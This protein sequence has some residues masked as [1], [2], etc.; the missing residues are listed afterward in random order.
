[1][2]YLYPTTTVY[3]LS[4]VL[5]NAVMKTIKELPENLTPQEVADYLRLSIETINRRIRDKQIDFFR[6]NERG[7]KRIPK[8]AVIEF[9]EKFNK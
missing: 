6:I 4:N 9:I 7:D 1:M 5:Y 2:R 3:K 8:K